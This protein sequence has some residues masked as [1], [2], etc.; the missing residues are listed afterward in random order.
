MQPNIW[1]LEV[2]SYLLCN[3]LWVMNSWTTRALWIEH[4]HPEKKFISCR[5]VMGNDRPEIS[6]QNVKWMYFWA[7]SSDSIKTKTSPY[8][9]TVF[10]FQEP[11]LVSILCLVFSTHKHIYLSPTCIWQSSLKI[12]LFLR[13]LT[14]LPSFLPTPQKPL[15]FLSSASLKVGDIYFWFISPLV[16]QSDI[17]KS[18]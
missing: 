15:T 16:I 10:C 14:V 18:L 3:F 2:H 8:H 13:K 5:K 4:C 7:L 12:N 11:S 1:S 6:V 17:S 9:H